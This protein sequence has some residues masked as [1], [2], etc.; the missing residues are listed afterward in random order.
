MF[1]FLLAAIPSKRDV[2]AFIKV[3]QTEIS[4]SYIEGDIQ[5]VKSVC[6]ECSKSIELFLSKVE[7][8]V[9]SGSEILSITTEKSLFVKNRFQDHNSQLVLLLSNLTESLDKLP[10]QIVKIVNDTSITSFDSSFTSVA[11]YSSK[12]QISDTSTTKGESKVTTLKS[13]LSDVVSRCQKRINIL[14]SEQLL[15]PTVDSLTLYVRSHL[16]G[17]LKEGSIKTGKQ[18]ESVSKDPSKTMQS[19]IH[20]LPNLCRCYLQNLATHPIVSSAMNEF[21]ARIECL[22]VSISAL[23]NPMNKQSI[24]SILADS[25]ALEQYLASIKNETKP[26]DCPIHREFK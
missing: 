25:A 14:L 21:I 20:L 8:M 3:A 4:Q 13:I 24:A 11:D 9:Y 16:L 18:T 6:K 7:G 12:Y 15:L 10:N 2:Q 1:I 17:G 26:S 5:L 19:L 23:S 22:F